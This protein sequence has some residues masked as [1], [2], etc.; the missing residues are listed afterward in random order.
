V[1]WSSPPRRE[2][3]DALAEADLNHRQAETRDLEAKTAREDR[4][5]DAEIAFLEAQ[6]RKIAGEVAQQPLE[7][8]ERRAGVEEKV[9]RTGEIQART[10]RIWLLNL[11]PSLLL[12]IGVIIGSVDSGSLA[13]SGFELFRGKTWLLPKLTDGG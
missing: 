9:A 2:L 1:P 7:A 4:L 13:S 11:L 6:T 5:E 3:V 8:E 12:A 10:V